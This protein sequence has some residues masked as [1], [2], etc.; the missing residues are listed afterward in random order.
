MPHFVPQ[1][2]EQRAILLVHCLANTL[3]RGIVGLL[4]V[5]CDDSV[6]MAR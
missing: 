2:T 3:A 4:D 6:G 5:D 1:V